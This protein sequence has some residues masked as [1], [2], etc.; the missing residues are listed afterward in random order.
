MRAI[1]PVVLSGWMKLVFIHFC[2][3]TLTGRKWMDEMKMRQ[4]PNINR[5]A[6]YALLVIFIVEVELNTAGLKCKRLMIG[7]K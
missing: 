3:S 5:L 4:V 1:H 2:P 7:R 6:L